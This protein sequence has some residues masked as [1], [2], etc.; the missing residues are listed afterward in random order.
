MLKLTVSKI[1]TKAAARFVKQHIRMMPDYAYALTLIPTFTITCSQFL[2][3]TGQ[4]P[5]LE[6]TMIALV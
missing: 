3:Q 6:N 2:F 4:I 1:V 5:W